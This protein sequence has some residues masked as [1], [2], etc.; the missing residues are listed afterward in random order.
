M[1]RLIFSTLLLFFFSSI[2]SAS[3]TETG[4][5]ASTRTSTWYWYDEDGAAIQ[6]DCDYTKWR[7]CKEQE[8]C[9]TYDAWKALTFAGVNT[10][11]P[12]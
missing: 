9:D 5:S 1:T 2:V 6:D 8:D 12:D 7:I 4:S 10:R 11:V 3:V